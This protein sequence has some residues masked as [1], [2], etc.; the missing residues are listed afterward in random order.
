MSF[1]WAR[2]KYMHS[3]QKQIKLFIQSQWKEW[4]QIRYGEGQRTGG[5][6][7]LLSCFQGSLPASSPITDGYS[8]GK[9]KSCFN[10][11]PLI[12]HRKDLLPFHKYITCLENTI[13]TLQGGRLAWWLKWPSRHAKDKSSIAVTALHSGQKWDAEK[14]PLSDSGYDC[15]PHVN[16]L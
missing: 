1:K 16:M 13:M 5:T 3:D 15:S 10:N 6:Q 11:H 14:N 8:L 9:K 7:P 4:T 12:V 2:N